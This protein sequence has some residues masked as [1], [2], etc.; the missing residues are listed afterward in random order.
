MQEVIVAFFSKLEVA[1][2]FIAQL[3][4]SVP[5]EVKKISFGSA[6]IH[7]AILFRASEM[8]FLGVLESEYGCDALTI[9]AKMLYVDVIVRQIKVRLI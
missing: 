2:P 7:L 3:S 6:L 1:M 9:N 8:A 5:P 4:L